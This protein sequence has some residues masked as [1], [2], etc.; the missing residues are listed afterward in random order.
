MIGSGDGGTGELGGGELGELGVGIGI[1]DVA[2][3]GCGS[4]IRGT[5]ISGNGEVHSG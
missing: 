5:W 3:P 2:G 1:G 4:G